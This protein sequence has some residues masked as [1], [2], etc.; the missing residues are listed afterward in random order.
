[1]MAPHD[2]EAGDAAV[3]GQE[4]LRLALG[5]ETSHLTFS[6]SRALMQSLILVKANDQVLRSIDAEAA[7]VIFSRTCK[8]GHILNCAYAHSSATSR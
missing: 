4:S 2:K 5:L 6:P 7:I 1:M 3:H 8:S